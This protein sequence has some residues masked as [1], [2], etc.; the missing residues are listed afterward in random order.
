M[1][2]SLKSTPGIKQNPERK[3]RHEKGSNIFEI[4]I[5]A[6]GNSFSGFGNL[7]FPK[8]KNLVH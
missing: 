3:H 6:A 1:I 8:I 4:H 2:N 5:S 7:Y